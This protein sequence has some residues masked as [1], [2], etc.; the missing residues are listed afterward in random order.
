MAAGVRFE[1]PECPVETNSED[2]VI[3]NERRRTRPVALARGE[4]RGVDRL[5]SPMF[6]DRF[7]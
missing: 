2:A 5:E 6:P 1:A 3:D 7:P 4:L